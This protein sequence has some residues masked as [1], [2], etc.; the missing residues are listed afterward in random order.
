MFVAAV[1]LLSVLGCNSN[2]SDVDSGS[3]T[4]VDAL[5]GITL[6]DQYGHPFQLASLK[7]RPVLFD[8]IY[9]TCPGPCLVLT[10]RMRAIAD[11]LGPDLGSKASLVSVTVDP[12]HDHSNVLRAYVKQQNAQRNGWYFLTGSPAEIDHLMSRFKLV[13]QREAD[14]TVDHVLEFFLVG[15]DGHPEM[16]YLAS[17]VMPAKV[18]G[19]MQRV[20]AG[21]QLASLYSTSRTSS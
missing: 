2:V 15:P 7:G 20:I 10:A 17:E 21:K 5:S 14:G 6:I 3:G 8:F 11:Y 18:A 16:Q 1:L 13:R 19:D 4:G 9:T 12:E